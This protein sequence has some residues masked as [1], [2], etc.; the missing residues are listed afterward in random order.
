MSSGPICESG[1]FLALDRQIDDPEPGDLLRAVDQPTI[2]NVFELKLPAA[3]P[4][5]G[6][7]DRFAVITRARAM[8][9]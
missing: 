2:R 8:T 7:G 4:K 5:S 1:D 3:P 9:T 6:D